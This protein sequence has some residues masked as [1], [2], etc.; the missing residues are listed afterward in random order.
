MLGKILNSLKYRIKRSS[1][2]NSWRNLDLNW[3]LRSGLSVA[4]ESQA[5]WVIYNDIYVD[6]EY[7]L[8]IQKALLSFQE[9]EDFLLLDIG[10]NVGFF[11]L[12]VIDLILINNPKA[13]IQSTLIEGSPAVYSTPALKT[14]LCYK[15]KFN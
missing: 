12:K 9:K 5:E 7:D 1:Q 8:A 13:K 6:G 14:N 2:N 11:S 10:A 3:T 15:I 4:V